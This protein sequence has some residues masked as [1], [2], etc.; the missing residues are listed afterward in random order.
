M[1]EI[2]HSIPPLEIIYKKVEADARFSLY[3]LNTVDAVINV[4]ND[5]RD[6]AETAE[7]VF[8]QILDRLTESGEYE[9]PYDATG[10]LAT[11]SAEAEGLVKEAILALQ[12]LNPK[13]GKSFSVEDAEVLSGSNEDAISALQ[14]LHDSM[15]DLRWAIAEHD[16]DLE[17]PEG[18]ALNNVEDLIAD[19]RSL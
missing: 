1:S 8:N 17:E 13:F 6:N 11:T 12:K 9:D 16:A 19:L 7:R 2:Q 4:A 18:K 5:F 14:R 15:V 3:Y 10:S